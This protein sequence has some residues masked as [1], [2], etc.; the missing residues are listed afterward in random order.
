MFLLSSPAWPHGFAGKR[1]F[2][3][4][5]ATDDP[6]VNDELT[7]LGSHIKEPG[8]GEE[9]DVLATEIE[10]EY[11]KTITPHFGLNL[12]G[13][14]RVLDP[15]SKGNTRSGFGNFE[16]GVK[17]QFFTSARHEMLMSLGFN[18]EVGDTGDRGVEADRF[19]TLSP[20]FFFGKGMGDLPATLNYLRPFAITGLVGAGIPTQHR[21]LVD[22]EQQHNPTNLNWGFALEYSLP[23]LQSF[24][25]DIGLGKP[26]NRLLPVVEFAATTCL[27]QGC[28]SSTSGIVSPGIIWLGRYMQAGVEAQIPINKRSGN[29]VGVFF[30]IHFFID[31]LFPNTLGRPLFG[32]KL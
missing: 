25:R 7:F 11:T 14:Y 18:A 31:D 27:D 16:V 22:G 1:F 15:Q 13:V 29:N 8:D 6:F 32:N 19:S 12:G 20:A 4:T 24:V 21:N 28:G 17:Y 30:Q 23:Y 2:P 10:A 3:S 5:L 9:P 26:F